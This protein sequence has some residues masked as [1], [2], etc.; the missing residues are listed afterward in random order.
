MSNTGNRLGRL[1]DLEH[2]GV[3]FDQTFDEIYEILLPGNIPGL[4]LP[5][6]IVQ[7]SDA[8]WDVFLASLPKGP[9]DAA[10]NE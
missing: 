2:I 8:Q 7:A 6:A 1:L 3:K 5:S 4:L 10:G 9:A